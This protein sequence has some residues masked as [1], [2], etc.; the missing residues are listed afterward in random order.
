MAEVPRELEVAAHI[1][2]RL[3]NPQKGTRYLELK[4]GAGPES[5]I[6]FSMR[7]HVDFQFRR[8]LWRQH[9]ALQP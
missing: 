1:T 3:P 9:D 4:V 7:R 2:T 5:F 6:W 8:P